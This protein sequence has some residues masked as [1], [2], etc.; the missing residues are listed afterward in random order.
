M[1]ILV[2]S[3][4]LVAMNLASAGPLFCIWLGRRGEGNDPAWDELGRKLAWLSCGAMFFGM[5]LGGGQMLFST[6][7]GLLNALARLPSRGLWIAVAE[8][9]FSM[10]CLL[11]YAGCWRSLRGHRWWHALLA[12]LSSSNLLY[13]FPPLMSIFGKLANSPTWA[14]SKVLDRPA[15]LQLMKRDEIVAL[16]VHFVLASFAVSAIA[17]LWLSS[18]SKDDD[19]EKSALPVARR[20]AWVALIVSAM[21]LPVGIWLLVTLPQ[22]ART[23]MMGDSAIASLAFVGALLLTFVLLQ[24]LLTIAIGRVESRDL[25][26]V[27]WIV[28][29][30]VLLMTTTLYKSRQKRKEPGNSNEKAAVVQIAPRLPY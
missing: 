17:V 5:F 12:L 4:H 22:S 18:R 28:V 30:L 1:I 24:R 9:A 21:Q 29:T 19:W 6:S 11:L 7:A 23:S 13:H 2:L 15:L 3:A 8:L 10:V 25:R 16:S 20:A 14:A 27:G 26:Q